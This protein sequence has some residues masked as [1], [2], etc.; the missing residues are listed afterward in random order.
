ME[1]LR[2]IEN[3][4]AARHRPAGPNASRSTGRFGRLEQSDIVDNAWPF[5]SSGM[6]WRNARA[7]GR[8]FGA[9]QHV[10]LSPVA[11]PRL[12]IWPPATQRRTRARSSS[13][14]PNGGRSSQGSATPRIAFRHGPDRP[15]IGNP[16]RRDR[17]LLVNALAI[18][19]LTPLGAAGE[20]LGMVQAP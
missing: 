9:A 1:G 16:Q 15:A 11:G 2:K 12:D 17:L 13:S 6:R 5:R 18:L 19:L 20:S 8:D 14:T 4:F 3:I 10:R 7:T